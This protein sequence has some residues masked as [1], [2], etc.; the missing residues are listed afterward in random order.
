MKKSRIKKEID[1]Y[2]KAQ[3]KALKSI[4]KERVLHAV[5]RT[6][7][8]ICIMVV[9]IYLINISPNYIV[10]KITKKT[11]VIINNNNV[12]SSLRS[13][14]FID[15]NENV[16][17]STA[18]I[19]NFFDEYLIQDENEIITTSNTK[20]VRISKSSN[21]MNVN[22]KNEEMEKA[23]YYDGSKVF[24][25][26]ETIENIYGIEARYN[27]E[28]DTL[29]F[30]SLN[31]KKVTAKVKEDTTI[32]Y[33]STQISRTLEKVKKDDEVTLIFDKNKDSYIESNGWIK[34]NSK[35]GTIGFIQRSK[36]EEETVIR[37]GEKENRIDGKVSLVWDY[38]NP[39]EI[40]PKRTEPINGVNVVSPSFYDLRENGIVSSNIGS[41]GM[42]YIEWAH[43]NGYE[44]WPTISNGFLNSLD[45]MSSMMRSFDS[46]ANLINNIMAELDKVNV[47][48]IS[49]DFENM[50]KEDKDKFSRF[51]IELA[52]RLQDK[53][54]KL[55]VC[56]TAPDGADT[57]S[58]CYDRYTIGKVADYVVFIGYDQTVGSSQVAG[59]V[60]GYDWDELNISKFIGQEG[61]SKKKVILA[62][63]FYTRL[64]EEKDGKVISTRVVNM[65]SVYIP[66]DAKVEWDSVRK[67][68][69]MTY[70]R[71]GSTFK[72]WIEDDASVKEKLNLVEKYKIAGAGFWEKDRE[73]EDI[74]NVI[75]EK[76][77]VK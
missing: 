74:W 77:Q 55:N 43:K 66:E 20:T 76:L 23:I 56:L 49:I 16:Y 73:K 57:W 54:I 59:T 45:A 47:D 68:N 46:R 58:L 75:S 61:I 19:N 48:G 67:Q 1:D 35:T 4:T 51:L 39:S 42:Q 14:I 52:P 32:K 33:K 28:K 65:N 36:L 2:I 38:Y 3:K 26:I 8:A 37:E 22:N 15:E 44:V 60:A 21:I 13:D 50:Y 5:R 40:C 72:M 64:W 25:P 41:S 30:E 53:N 18:D 71:E 69:Y 31:R 63:P 12:T 10:E 27:K 7:I 11:K 17:M 29:V 34:V 9:I 62:V 70:T 6:S 24:L